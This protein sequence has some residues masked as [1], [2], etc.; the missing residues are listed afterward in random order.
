MPR[1]A[2]IG[3]AFL[4][5]WH[6]CASIVA[7]N[8]APAPVAPS[9][10]VFEW[11]AIEGAEGYRLEISDTKEF[12]K[13]L[14]SHDVESLEKIIS[15]SPN[16]KFY[17]R[18]AGKNFLGDLGEWSETGFVFVKYVPPPPPPKVEALPPPPPAPPQKVEKVVAEKL[19]LPKYANWLRFGITS[20]YRAE[21]VTG[22]NYNVGVKGFWMGR[23]NLSGAFRVKRHEVELRASYQRQAFEVLN[24]SLPALQPTLAVDWIRGQ[25]LWRGAGKVAGFPLTLGVSFFQRPSL[26]PELGETLRTDPI[27]GFSFLA[28]I[29]KYSSADLPNYVKWEILADIAPLGQWRHLGASFEVT[30]GYIF[31]KGELSLE[32]VAGIHPLFYK[33]TP[34]IERGISID[35]SGGMVLKWSF[36]STAKPVAKKKDK[37]ATPTSQ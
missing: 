19:V 8:L 18:V 7:Q 27:K 26:R 9:E 13:V 17:W 23:V 14:Q 2:H 36:G 20:G 28:G 22:E 1:L 25:A 37:E 16:K 34:H 33:V 6:L 29:S 15:L 32:F 24:S 31:G 30:S 11:D 5:S 12:T 10:V 35:V 4:L 21:G 3:F